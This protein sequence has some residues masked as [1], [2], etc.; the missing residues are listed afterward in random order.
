MDVRRRVRHRRR[1]HREEVPRLIVRRERLN[2]TVVARRRLVPGHHGTALAGIVVHLDVIRTAA[3]HRCLGVHY[4]HLEAARRSI[5]RKIGSST[6]NG[7]N[8]YRELAPGRWTTA[9]GGHSHVVCH[10]GIVPGDHRTAA[11]GIVVHLDVTRTND[12]G[13]S[14]IHRHRYRIQVLPPEEQLAPL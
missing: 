11:A 8:S 5:A 10:G 2:P 9:H 7:G 1:P 12:R 4:R 3:D 13:G 6:G 14:V